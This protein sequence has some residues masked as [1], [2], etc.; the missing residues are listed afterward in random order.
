L[1]A[2]I[3]THRK[4]TLMGNILFRRYLRDNKWVTDNLA[5]KN[6]E[7]LR[8]MIALF[9]KR[10]KQYALDRP[11]LAAL[12]Y[13][14]SGLDQNRRSNQGAVG[15]MQ[16]RRDRSNSVHLPNISPCGHRA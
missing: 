10:G 13:Q 4:G 2:F 3:R 16:I 5:E 14:E 7:K 11:M 6:L 15:V 9:R 8:P 12:G 1:D